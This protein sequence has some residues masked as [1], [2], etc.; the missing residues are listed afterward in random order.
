[1]AATERRIDLLIMGWGGYRRKGFALGS[2]V[3][4]V[5]KRATSNVIVVKNCHPQKYRSVLVSFAGGLN[6]AFALEVAS[7]LVKREGGRVIVFHVSPP[8]K[9]T[10]DIEAFLKKAVTSLGVDISLFEPKYAISHNLLKTLL[11]EAEQYDLV[12]IGGTRERLFRQAVM[13]TLPEEFA[14]HCKKPLVMVKVSHPVKS[15]VRRWI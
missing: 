15:F 11:E 4:P 5:L 10:Q 6:S 13:G 14:R 12:I 8:N 3:D 1:L 2:T 9:P 7:I